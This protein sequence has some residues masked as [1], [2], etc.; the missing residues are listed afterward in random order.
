MVASVGWEEAHREP[1]GDNRLVELEYLATAVWEEVSAVS[2]ERAWVPTMMWLL[3][4][5]HCW[6]STGNDDE[7]LKLVECVGT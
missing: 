1:E 7:W 6:K 4:W 3:L 2:D 5:W